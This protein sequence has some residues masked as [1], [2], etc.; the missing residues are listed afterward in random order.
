MVLKEELEELEGVRSAQASHTE[1]KV[2]LEY[3]PDKASTKRMIE[4]ITNQGFQVNE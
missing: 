3:D 1:G 2:N 4:I